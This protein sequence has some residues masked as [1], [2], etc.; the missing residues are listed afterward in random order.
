MISFLSETFLGSHI[1]TNSINS[2]K[3]AAKS[4]PADMDQC[5]LLL[6]D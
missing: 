4:M 3:L 5:N 2:D 1:S 6:V